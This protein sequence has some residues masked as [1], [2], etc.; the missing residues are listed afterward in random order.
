MILSPVCL[1]MVA[2]AQAGRSPSPRTIAQSPVLFFS[3][4]WGGEEGI[5]TSPNACTGSYELA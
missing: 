2:L 5:H 3:G 1:M 4:G